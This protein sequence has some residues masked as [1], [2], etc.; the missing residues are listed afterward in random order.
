MSRSYNKVA[1]TGFAISNHKANSKYYKQKR[2]LARNYSKRECI[3]M[4][5]D[6]FND[7]YEFKD[8]INNYYNKNINVVIYNRQERKL[9]RNTW[10]EP[11]DGRYIWFKP[12]KNKKKVYGNDWRFG[13]KDHQSKEE[14][15]EIYIRK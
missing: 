13:Y 12:R 8:S 5:K 7:L 1:T 4:I 14:L 11:T 9:H 15:Y 6:A 2:K 3:R 10:D